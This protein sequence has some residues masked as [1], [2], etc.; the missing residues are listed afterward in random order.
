MY[1]GRMVEIA[2]SS[3][4]FSKPRHPYTEALL[5]AKP[6]P[7]PRIRSKRIILTGEIANPA[8][9]PTGCYFHTRC[10]YCEEICKTETPPFE[11][12]ETDHFVACHCA[13]ELDLRGVYRKSAVEV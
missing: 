11:E 4:V 6:V 2:K 12:I 3:A 10:R 1:V 5:S 8:N 7:D 9:P 13:R